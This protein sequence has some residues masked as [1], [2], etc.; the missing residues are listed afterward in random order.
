MK[1]LIIAGLLFIAGACS[2][3]SGEKEAP[4]DKNP[5]AEGFDLEGSDSLAIAIADQVMEA[6]GGRKAWDE[7]RYFQWDF[8]GAR[9]HLWDKK[10][11]DIRIET[12]DTA[13]FI[14]NIEGGPG[15][16]SNKGTTLEPND[17]LQERAV[18]MWINDAYWLFMPFKLKDSGVTLKYLREDVTLTG[19]HAHVL[20]LTFR[21]VG[22]TPDNRYEVYVD[23][24]TNLVTQWVFYRNY[25][26]EAPGFVTPW[27]G[28]APHGNLM[29]GGDRGERQI[30]HIAVPDSIPDIA[31]TDHTWGLLYP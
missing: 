6:Q 26:D 4:V 19:G 2:T 25:D 31:F 11:G 1:I 18:S 20:G 8:F 24:G 30:T 16:F 29:L 14:T 23:K 12:R 17:S 22:V 3:P 28:Y 10:T 9:R 13:V 21:E 15:Q 5:P 27:A 7:A